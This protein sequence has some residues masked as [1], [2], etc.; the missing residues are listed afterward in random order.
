MVPICAV[1]RLHALTVAN[2]HQP[3]G[4]QHFHGFAQHSP[5]YSED[6]AKLRF[7]GKSDAFGARTDDLARQPIYHLNKQLV[8]P[9]WALYGR[10]FQGLNAL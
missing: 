5:A 3:L 8:T 7:S 9:D 2:L 4:F 6:A 10:C 1:A